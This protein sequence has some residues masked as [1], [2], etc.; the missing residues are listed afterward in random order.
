MTLLHSLL[1]WLGQLLLMAV[2]FTQLTE[3]LVKQSGSRLWLLAI[4]LVL[5]FA[6]PLAG[7]SFA[8]WLRSVLGDLSVLTMLLFADIL[9]RRLW[10]L[11][12]FS[13]TARHALL[14][15]VAV[16]GMVFYP[17]A[18]GVGSIDPYR[19]GFAPVG[20]SVALCVVSVITWLRF[21]RG[22][23]VALLLPL[24][25]YNLHLLESDN[26]WNYLIDPVLVIYAIVQMT[27]LLLNK[28]VTV[29]FP[30]P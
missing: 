23:A 24:L 9:A 30:R 3:R 22:L 29:F 2:L 16:V 4:L 21:S 1:P 19:L 26:L 8:Q 7:S 6:V 25:A 5:G 28:G 13:I 18:M 11:A 14:L 20:L 17:M 12:L 27:V 10:G 15:V